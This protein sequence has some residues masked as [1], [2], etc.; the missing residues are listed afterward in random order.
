MIEGEGGAEL[1]GC[2]LRTER[3][4][5]QIAGC[6]HRILRRKSQNFVFIYIKQNARYKLRI[7]DRLNVHNSKQKV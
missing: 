4:K 1:R 2:N 7:L 5:V 6:K 3:K